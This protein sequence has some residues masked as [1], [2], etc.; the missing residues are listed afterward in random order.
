MIGKINQQG[1]ISGKLTAGGGTNDHNRLTNRDIKDQHP[2]EAITGLAEALGSKLDSETAMPLIEDA[3]KNKAKGLFFD[4]NKELSRKSYWY[5][6]SE[7]DPVTKMGTKESV[8]SGPYDL[9]AGGGGG[10]G[11]GVTDIKLTVAVNPET[12]MPFWPGYVAVGGLCQIGMEWSSTRDGTPTGR[13]TMYVYVNNSLVETKTV[14][15]GL[16]MFD[17]TQ[18]IVSG[19][20]KIE[21]KVIDNYSTTKNY[22]DMISGVT[23]KLSSNFE[24]DISYTGDIIFTYTP[25]GAIRKTVHFILDGREALTPD[26][27]DTTGEQ[28]SKLIPATVLSTHGAHNLK[29]YF[30]AEMDGEE[31]RSN[32]LY[33]DIIWVKPGNRTPIIASTYT[34]T[35]EEQYTSFTVKYRVYTPGKN[36]STVYLETDGVRSDPLSVDQKF[37]LWENRFDTTGDHTLRIITENVVKVFNISVKESQIHVEPVTDALELALSSFGRKNSEDPDKRCRWDYESGTKVIRG[38][39]TGF[40]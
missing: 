13:G 21:V 11:G 5:L 38:N 2:I 10:G 4:V 16:V 18:Y 33:F 31:I 39:L 8:I 28:K 9:G 30:V 3:V 34:N 17:L 7:I 22:V 32:E 40:N 37:Q 27:V 1:G 14:A 26:V 29:V 24:D 15:Q 19:E 12:G 25:T 20:N 23:I 36:R 6:T 35:T